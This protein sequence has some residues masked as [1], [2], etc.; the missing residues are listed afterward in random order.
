MIG[1]TKPTGGHCLV[2]PYRQ[3]REY[4]ET[5]WEVVTEVVFAEDMRAEQTVAFIDEVVL[6]LARASG[7]TRRG[8]CS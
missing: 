4:Q 6:E 2:E 3:Y 1:V 5:F 8:A 7:E